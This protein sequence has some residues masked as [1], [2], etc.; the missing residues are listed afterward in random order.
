MIRLTRF[1]AENFRSLVNIRLDDLPEV[2]LLYG[3][4]DVGK[5]NILRAVGAWLKLAA[6]VL[7]MTSDA[8]RVDDEGR[9][10]FLLDRRTAGRV[11]GRPVSSQFCYEQVTMKLSGGLQVSSLDFELGFTIELLDD[12]DPKDPEVAAAVVKVTLQGVEWPGIGPLRAAIPASDPSL[13]AL[14]AALSDPWLWISSERRFHAEL[15]QESPGET[16]PETDDGGDQTP[17]PNGRGLLRGLFRAHVGTDRALR[18]AFEQR[19][20]SMLADGPFRLDTPRP[21]LDELGWLDLWV[22]DRSIRE[23]G[24]GPR[25]WAL[26][27]GMMAM[28][29]AGIIG[30]EE[31]EANLSWDARIKIARRLVAEVRAPQAAPYQ[32]FITSHDGTMYE[33]SGGKGWYLVTIA[34]GATQV[35]PREGPKGLDALV[36][37]SQ[38]PTAPTGS[39]RLYPGGVVALPDDLVR[40]LGAEVGSFLYPLLGDPGEIRLVGE[41]RFEELVTAGSGDEQARGAK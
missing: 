32:M 6:H 41:D 27:T 16:V 34:D 28:S 13:I 21:V 31:P 26:I 12:A 35:T 24:S 18:R 23:H 39:M 37:V 33:A 20:V 11:L 22:G 30:L 4:N 10:T 14:R 40:H 19:F 5:S 29:G 3:E 1:H 9:A 2:V 17:A 8:L 38:I 15:A 7:Y 25:Q 36:P